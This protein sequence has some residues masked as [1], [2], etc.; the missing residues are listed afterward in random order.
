MDDAYE[1]RAGF[2]GGMMGSAMGGLGQAGNQNQLG[3]MNQ[4]QHL[5]GLQ[6]YA[7]GYST[8]HA[9]AQQNS[10]QDGIVKPN[11]PPA[12]AGF[13]TFGFNASNGFIE[14]DPRR[15]YHDADS[16]SFVDVKT[17]E[18]RTCEY[19]IEMD[20]LKKNQ[21]IK[22]KKKE[23]SMF[24]EFK[25]DMK[26]FMAEHKGMIYGLI[27]I[28]LLDHFFLEGKLKAK[29]LDLCHRMLGKMENK[30]DA[31]GVTPDGKK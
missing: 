22:C 7:N 14:I 8:V 27:G 16:D 10:I 11:K 24:G 12:D 6:Q 29:L 15:Y 13:K 1:L 31:I 18:K 30:I 9:F 23:L 3:Q 21:D 25:K 17:G 20:R 2:Y 5:G 4:N 26:T 19:F 28:Y